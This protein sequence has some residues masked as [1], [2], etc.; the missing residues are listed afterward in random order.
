MNSLP[1][2]VT[3]ECCGCELNPGPSAPESS[4]LTTR[5]PSQPSA[6]WNYMAELPQSQVAD[7]IDLHLTGSIFG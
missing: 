2:I 3:R 1:K 6:D 5:L 4:M 7:D